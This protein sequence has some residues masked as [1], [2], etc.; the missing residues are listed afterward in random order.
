MGWAIAATVIVVTAGGTALGTDVVSGNAVFAASLVGSFA[1]GWLIGGM[2][3]RFTVDAPDAGDGPVPHR[4]LSTTWSTIGIVSLLNGVD[5]ITT[6]VIP[7]DWRV[8]TGRTAVLVVLGVAG[9]ELVRRRR[10]ARSARAMVAKIA[11]SRMAIDGSDVWVRVRRRPGWARVLGGSPDG[12]LLVTW[13][14]DAAADR[15]DEIPVAQVVGALW[16][17]GDGHQVRSLG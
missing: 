9:F 12:A 8:T 4:L 3:G 7:A 6:R 17:S 2:H 5:L 10:A 1:I 14:G 16:R 13:S 15:V 11:R